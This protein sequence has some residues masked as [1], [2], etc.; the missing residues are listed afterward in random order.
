MP[1]ARRRMPQWLLWTILL[2]CTGWCLTRLGSVLLPI[3]TGRIEPVKVIASFTHDPDAGTPPW[4]ATLVDRDIPPREISEDVWAGVFSRRTSDFG[5][6]YPIFKTRPTLL[7]RGAPPVSVPLL[8]TEDAAALL[9]A[10]FARLPENA[11]TFMVALRDRFLETQAPR[12]LSSELDPVAIADMASF[13]LAAAGALLASWRLQRMHAA[14]T[15][16]PD[17]PCNGG[18]GQASTIRR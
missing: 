12:R 4:R 2:A 17:A 13:L 3:R 15:V 1:D 9:Y 16:P 11:D 5:I 14:R 10:E 6:P 7:I 18:S 8:S